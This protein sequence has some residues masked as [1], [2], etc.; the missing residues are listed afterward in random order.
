MFNKRALGVSIK[1]HFII[2]S[3]DQI[4]IAKSKVPL[5]QATLD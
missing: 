3:G 1:H 2:V 5:T 4:N